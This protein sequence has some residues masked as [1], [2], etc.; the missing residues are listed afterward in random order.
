M[1]ED[2]FDGHARPA[3]QIPGLA[4]FGYSKN[5]AQPIADP[6]KARALL[7]DAGY[8]NVGPD[9]VLRHSKNRTSLAAAIVGQLGAVGS[10]ALRKG[11]ECP[12]FLELLSAREAGFV[13]IGENN[14]ALDAGFFFES[15][16]HTPVPEVGLGDFNFHNF[17]DEEIDR[18]IEAA[19]Q[20]MKPG[21]R[22]RMYEEISEWLAQSNGVFPLV[23]VIDLFGVRRNVEWQPRSDGNIW[24]SEMKRKR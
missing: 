7:K 24:I 8:K 13:L 2:V 15:V 12:E 6:S 18:L 11:Y 21:E 22:Q 16:I 4:A 14:S 23:W 3:N 20:E 10:Q 19:A 1:V 9:L 17:S 5:L